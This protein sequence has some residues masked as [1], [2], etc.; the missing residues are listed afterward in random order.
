MDV[1]RTR[2]DIEDSINKI[3]YS[4][5]IMFMGSCFA[6][7]IGNIF[8]D[9]KFNTFVNPFGVTYNPI[10]VANSLNAILDN[11]EYTEDDI[12][13]T[14]G[15]WVSMAH[16]GKFSHQDKQFCLNRLN[17]NNYNARLFL[18]E[19]SYLVITFG[20]AWVYESI[21][22]RT[23]VSNCHKLPARDFKRYRLTVEEIVDV[24]RELIVMLKHFNP[25]IKIIFTLSPIR[26][27]KDGAQE[28]QLSKSVLLLAINELKQTLYNVD[29]FPSYEIVMDE[30]RDYRFYA[31]DMIHV[32]PLTVNYIWQRFKETN[33][34]KS[35]MS[36]MF[37][38]SKL[39]KSIQHRPLVAD[40]QEYRDFLNRLLVKIDLL[41][42]KYP[43]INFSKERD[44]VFERINNQG[45]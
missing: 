30:L 29:Y 35:V 40:T 17:S 26:H 4:H 27:W 45:N 5:K 36:A 25:N 3:D 23:V 10:S 24:Y 43:D 42:R 32:S 18:E 12:I 20:T 14:N 8:R 2:I 21:E 28:N 15:K 41:E 39:T 7:S 22:N 9:N 16:H 6:D 13:F 33:I 38:V 31:E 1:F 37:D 19:T 34:S 11:K 44:V